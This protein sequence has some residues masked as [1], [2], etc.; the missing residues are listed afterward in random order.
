ML[1]IGIGRLPVKSV[2]EANAVVEKIIHYSSAKNAFG[3]GRNEICFIADDEDNNLHFNYAEKLAVLVDTTDPVFNISKIYLDAF[4]QETNSNGQFYPDVNHAITDKINEGVNIIDYIGHGYYNGLAHEQILTE[5]DLDNWDNPNYYPLMYAATGDFG[6]FDDPDK[7]SLAE[8]ALLLE[9]KGLSAIVAPTRATYAG[10]NFILQREFYKIIMNNQDYTLGKAFKIAKQQ[11]GGSENTKKYCFL[12][13]PSMKLA[14]PEYK[15]TTEII[16]GTPVSYPLDT[17][18]PGEQVIV[19]GYI[20]DSDG[21]PYYNFNGTMEV[22]V[23]DRID[24]L[25]TLGNDPQSI[26]TDFTVWDS[27]LL[28]LNT[29]ILNGQFAFSFNLPYTLNEE[30]GTLKLSYYGIDY[31]VDA[32]GQFSGLVVGG[33]ANA[34]PENE[35]IDDILTLYPTLVT[36]DLFF[37]AKQNIN[38]LQLELYDLTGRRILEYSEQK[39]PT[40]TKSGIN[41][42]GLKAGMYIIRVNTDNRF[43][44]FKIIKQ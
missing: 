43:N 5:E 6:H 25:S 16:N 4:E 38:N 35:S 18:N 31:P 7:Y 14:I 11:T 15:V 32:R 27:V 2:D 36:S 28:I 1:Q 30:Y 40:G 23:Y 13:D 29:D 42:S 22:K 41:L 9:G 10:G 39:I 19:S 44:T 34:I 12:G 26:V 37:V 3:S 24:T 20:V 33:P 21:E 8:Q 17:I